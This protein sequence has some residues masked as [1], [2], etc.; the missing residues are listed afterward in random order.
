MR[1][2]IC[3]AIILQC[4]NARVRGGCMAWETE[5][6]NKLM[7]ADEA[8]DRYVSNGMRIYT[9][10]LH[11][12]T[13]LI[14]AL[15]ERVKDGRLEGID[16]WGNWMNGK[17]PF[18]ELDVPRSAF[19]YHT[20]FA[21]PNERAGFGGCVSHIPVHFSDVAGLA[22]SV[23]PDLCILSVTPPNEDGL[24]NIGP[25][26]FT[27]DFVPQCKNIIAQVNSKLPFVS[28]DCHTIPVSRISAFVEH[29]EELEDLPLKEPSAEERKAAEY[30]VDRVPDGSTIQLGIGGISDAIG[31]GL[32]CKK[33]LGAYTE[34]YSDIFAKLQEAGVIDNSRKNYRPGVSIGGYATGAKHLYDFLDNNPDVVFASY[35]EVCNP[36]RIAMNDNL[37]SINTAISIDLTGQVCA[38]SIGPRQYSAS[39]GQMNYVQGAKYS[40]GG[41]SYICVTSVAHTKKGDV[42][43]IVPT[44]TPGSAITTPRNEVGCI[45]TEYGV[46]ELRYQ[47]IPERVR[48]LIAIAHPDFRD[49]LER[50][51]RKL[52][53]LY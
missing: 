23:K 28:G 50:E 5:Y 29:D 24:C 42:S 30:V 40:N 36:M 21:G 25:L 8:I 46:A 26:G 34:M 45:V 9:S 6:R 43:K 31:A 12:A 37:I 38:E 48:R 10:G 17:F 1:C 2:S 11:V 35:N 52:G 20:Y 32:F 4:L 16:T 18:A 44:L 7:S 13:E 19:R 15:I 53:Y 41:E 3:T 14:K 27:A 47:D 22:A 51:A 49:E 39:G 33:H